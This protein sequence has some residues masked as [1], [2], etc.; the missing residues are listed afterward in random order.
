MNG[1][2]S[3]KST[4]DVVLAPDLGLLHPQHGAA[5]EDVLPAAEL[6]VEAAAQ[7]QDGGHAVVDVDL[8]LGGRA[9]PGEQAQQGGL[10][11]PVA[12]D[13]ADDLPPAH[14][15]GDV[16]QGPRTAGAAGGG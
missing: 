1:P 12:P 9:D 11:R 16:A 14:V 6:G 7:L 5:E 2:S 4:I 3:A 10:P 8:A 15:E 13:H